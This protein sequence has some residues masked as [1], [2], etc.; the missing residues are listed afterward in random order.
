[1]TQVD[2]LNQLAEDAGR[3]FARFPGDAPMEALARHLLLLK[4]RAQW[5]PE[6]AE[7]D[8]ATDPH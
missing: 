7:N 3:A 6:T 5:F 8:I 1:M 2:R 4:S